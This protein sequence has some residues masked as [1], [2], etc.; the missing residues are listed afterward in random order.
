MCTRLD[1][2]GPLAVPA[3]KSTIWFHQEIDLKQR[4]HSYGWLQADLMFPQLHIK[5]Y[6]LDINTSN[7]P[8]SIANIEKRIYCVKVF[9]Q[10]RE[11]LIALLHDILNFLG[12]S[13]LCS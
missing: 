8:L 4:S 10:K 9:I 11:G 1:S 6:Y 2:G 12:T 3:K 5:V 13:I 7:L